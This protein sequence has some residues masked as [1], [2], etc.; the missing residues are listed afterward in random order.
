MLFDQL[1]SLVRWN[2]MRLVSVFY[3]HYAKIGYFFQKFWMGIKQ[4]YKSIPY[5]SLHGESIVIKNDGDPI[6]MC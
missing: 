1:V 6:K 4:F 2:S 3:N 5:E